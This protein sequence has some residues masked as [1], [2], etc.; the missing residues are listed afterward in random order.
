MPDDPTDGPV[1]HASPSQFDRL[2]DIEQAADAIFLDVGIGPFTD[3]GA[4]AHLTDAAVVLAVGEPPVGF[5]T[6]GTVDGIA[7]LWQLAVHPDHGRRGHGTALV[8]AVCRWARTHGGGAV[9]LT[10]FRDVPWNAP[11]YRGLGFRTLSESEL[12]P[13][14]AAIRDHERAIGDDAFGPRVAM[15]WDA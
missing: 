4:D 9:T 2:R 13:A 14:L 11:F 3:D 15:R 12:S 6:V 5:A 1:Y 7:H 8:D 10:T